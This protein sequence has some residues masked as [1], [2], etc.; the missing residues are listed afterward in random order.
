VTYDVLNGALNPTTCIPYSHHNDALLLDHVMEE[1]V[2][3]YV[4]LPRETGVIGV[5][6]L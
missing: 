3:G 6:M 2:N 4:V 5:L 1:T